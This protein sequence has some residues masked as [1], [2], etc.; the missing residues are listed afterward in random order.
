MNIID[1]DGQ[2]WQPFVN[3]FQQRMLRNV[4]TGEERHD[5]RLGRVSGGVSSRDPVRAPRDPWLAQLD[6]PPFWGK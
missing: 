3:Q 6:D 1:K 4:A 5:P 2:E